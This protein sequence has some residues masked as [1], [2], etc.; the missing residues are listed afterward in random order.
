LG[1]K[2]IRNSHRKTPRPIRE[3]PVFTEPD[4]PFELCHAEGRGFESLQPLS[5][6]PRIV[7]VFL[8]P[9]PVHSR[10]HSS[11]KS[12]VQQMALR[13]DCRLVSGGGK[14]KEVVRTVHRWTTVGGR[15][16]SI[17]SRVGV[18]GWLSSARLVRQPTDRVAIPRSA[19]LAIR[20]PLSCRPRQG[21]PTPRTPTASSASPSRKAPAGPLR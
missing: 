13:H 18:R 11:Y 7:G 12:S 8:F 9:D 14:V 4:L 3:S 16:A 6:K 2:P 19:A 5:E 1:T 17:G 20:S 21:L 10:M 15:K